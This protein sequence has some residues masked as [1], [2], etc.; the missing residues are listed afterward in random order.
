[1]KA[2]RVH[3]T[4]GPEVMEWTD[5]PTPEP[6]AGEVLVRQEAVGVNYIDTYHRSGLY[7][8]DLPTSLGIEGAG[9]VERIGAGVTTLNQG[10]RVAYTGPP[11]TYAEYFTVAADRAIRLPNG[12]DAQQGAAA[13]VQGMTAHYLSHSTYP[14][15]GDD[16]CLIHAAAGGVGLLLVQMAKMRGARVLATVSTEEKAALARQAG[17]DRVIRYT[18]EDFLEAVKQDTDG[19]GVQVVYDSVGKTTFMKSLD[20]L[21]PL[22]LLALFGQSSGKVESFDPAI[23]N[24]KGSLYLT[25]P[26]MSHYVA[27]RESLERRAG[28]VLSWI[29]GGALSVRIG[30]TWPLAEAADAH[31]ALHARRTTGK[32]VLIP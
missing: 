5:V 9:I 2:I 6:G 23:L 20:C 10:D 27:D 16:T 13:M 7:P 17:A 11:G 31:R 30:R 18:E 19:R 32:V 25:R 15:S 4:G 22:G 29:A 8:L 12:I 1:M 24:A 28:E 21:A 3:A 14:L 26:T